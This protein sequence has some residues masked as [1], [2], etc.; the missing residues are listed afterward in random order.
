MRC[1]NCVLP[2]NYPDIV[3]DKNGICNY[4]KEFTPV[5]YEGEKAFINR[6]A[7]FKNKNSKY[8]CLVPLSGGRDSTYVLYQVKFKYGMKPL[9]YHYHNGFVSQI[10]EQ[11]IRQITDKLNIDLVTIKTNLQKKIVTLVSELALEKS[12][13]HFRTYLCS[14]C[15][16]GIK[17][18]AFKVAKENNIQ[19]IIFGESRMEAGYAKKIHEKKYS[20]GSKDKIKSVCLH[21]FNFL[22]RKYYHYKWDRTFPQGDSSVKMINFF[23]YLEWNESIIMDT[24]NKNTPWQAAGENNAWRF[25]CLI[26]CLNDLLDKKIYG[27][28]EKDELY[29][30]M[31]RAGKLTRD[32]AIARIKNDNHVEPLLINEVL[33]ILHIK[34]KYKQQL[35]G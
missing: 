15:G 34:D 19:L 35:L 11:N 33:N 25:D 6:I 20:F 1:S 21:P 14:N 32:E 3:F 17:D 27:F 22:K 30:K 29:S 4:C 10:A 28:T 7:E 2:D 18:G 31:I 16:F 24:I 5:L 26:H 23:D 8:D 9:C 13:H 12:M